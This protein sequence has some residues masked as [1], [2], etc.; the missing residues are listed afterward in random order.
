MKFADYKVATLDAQIR[1]SVND[2]VA[3]GALPAGRNR[4]PGFHV[5]EETIT[6]DDG[7]LATVRFHKARNV[8]QLAVTNENGSTVIKEAANLTELTY[9]LLH[10]QAQDTLQRQDIEI[11]N[12]RLEKGLL[13]G[14]DIVDDTSRETADWLQ[15]YHY[16]QIYR[17][18]IKP[19]SYEEE[20]KMYSMMMGMLGKLRLPLTA[21]NLDLAFRTLWDNN[22]EF[23]GYIDKARSEKQRLANEAAALAQAQEDQAAKIYPDSQ[24]ATPYAP[25]FV[26]MRNA[27]TKRYGADAELTTRQQSFA[28]RKGISVPTFED[29]QIMDERQ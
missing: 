13:A 8:Y 19:L 9:D 5:P 3:A 11:E 23:S 29:S 20:Q 28:R 16:G 15:N 27:G 10:D 17:E 25:P 7:R 26:P 6:L 4:E 18:T 12:E 2:T 1:T 21:P 14:F 24:P 22:D